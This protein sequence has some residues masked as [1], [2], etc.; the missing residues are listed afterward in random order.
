MKLGRRIFR[1]DGNLFID[2]KEFIWSFKL[3]LFKFCAKQNG[4]QVISL[5]SQISDTTACARFVVLHWKKAS[6]LLSL[7]TLA[8]VDITM[9]FFFSLAC[10]NLSAGI[11]WINE[12]SGK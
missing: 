2:R 5:A 8:S 10:H 7:F 3:Y 9:R 4:R 11:T 6:S 12:H 1:E